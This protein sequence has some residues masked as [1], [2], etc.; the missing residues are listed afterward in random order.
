MPVLSLIIY[1]HLSDR[2]T[3]P[4]DE[5]AYPVSL[6]YFIFYNVRLS[7]FYLGKPR[8]SPASFVGIFDGMDSLLNHI[9]TLFISFNNNNA[10]EVQVAGHNMLKAQW[11]TKRH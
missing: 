4:G 2:A 3:E 11:Q 1:H 9:N 10:I 7:L 5:S 8:P 6:E